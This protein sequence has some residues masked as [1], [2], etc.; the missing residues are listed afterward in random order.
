MKLQMIFNQYDCWILH[1]D[2]NLHIVSVQQDFHVL[3]NE[4]SIDFELT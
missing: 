3:Q 1:T 4:A 2:N